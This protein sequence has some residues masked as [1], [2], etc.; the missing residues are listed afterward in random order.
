MPKLQITYNE[1]ENV[2]R[3]GVKIE[4][5]DDNGNV[6]NTY[7][8][9]SEY[10]DPECGT[11]VWTN[12]TETFDLSNDAIVAVKIGIENHPAYEEKKIE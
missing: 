12:Q 11:D 8:N 5:V 4:I 6:Q 10:L 9:F 7:T 1:I 2:D 3:T